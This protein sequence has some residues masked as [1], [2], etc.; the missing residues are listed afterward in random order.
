MVWTLNVHFSLVQPHLFEKPVS[1][2]ETG[3]P[4]NGKVYPETETE[5]AGAVA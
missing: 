3:K 2:I 5:I 1:T 4:D